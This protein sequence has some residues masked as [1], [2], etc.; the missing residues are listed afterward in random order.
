MGGLEVALTGLSADADVFVRLG[1]KPTT[2]AYSCYHVG[3]GTAPE[4]C[5]LSLPAGGTW[6]IG[7]SNYTPNTAIGYTLTATWDLTNGVSI[8]DALPVGASRALWK[9]YRVQVPPGAARF[10]ATLDNLTN[11]ADLFTRAGAKPD[12]VN[13]ACS[14]G[15]GG[16]TVDTC[17]VTNPQSGV[18]WIGV[19]N[20]ATAAIS[21]RLTAAWAGSQFHG[22]TPCRLI[23]TRNPTGALGGPALSAWSVRAFSLAGACGVPGTAR[24]LSTN[25]TVVQGGAPGSLRIYA[26]GEAFPPSTAI[27]FAAG[28]TRAN[29]AMLKLSTDGTGTIQVYDESAA[30]IHVII[31]VNGYFE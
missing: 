14:S 15:Q 9:Y 31:D 23:D 20:W 11:D 28:R 6:W 1:S 8:N 29:N 2:S 13:V 12:L 3:F 22:L 24:A 18:W 26:A 19:N 21:Y 10:T 5:T 30:N 16:T 7:V 27:T 4:N 25:V 17:T